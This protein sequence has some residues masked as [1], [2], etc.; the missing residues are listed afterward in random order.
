MRPRSHGSKKHCNRGRHAE[1][2]FSPGGRAREK[3]LF[4]DAGRFPNQ[5]V[6][7][8][9][10]EALKRTARALEARLDSLRA[11][12]GQM[13]QGHATLNF[14]AIV[15]EEECVGCG[16]CMDTCPAEAIQL[17]QFVRVDPKRCTGC[18]GCIERCPQGAISLRPA[19]PFEEP[20]LI[21]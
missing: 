11:R 20:S 5:T 10:I 17:E 8:N 4:A 19:E 15:D 16:I 3:L 9:E 7:E 13:E 2:H 12:I 18:G 6:P 1:R 21:A 14:V